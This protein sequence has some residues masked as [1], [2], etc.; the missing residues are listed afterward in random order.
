LLRRKVSAERSLVRAILWKNPSLALASELP[1]EA[2]R[3]IDK[4]TMSQSA[5]A[6][7]APQQGRWSLAEMLDDV[8]LMD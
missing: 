7:R 5:S 4:Q 8:F 2:Y 3:L 1:D 6:D